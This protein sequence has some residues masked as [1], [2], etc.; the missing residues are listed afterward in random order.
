[1]NERTG[2]TEDA[3]FAYFLHSLTY[4][5]ARGGLIIY[6]KTAMLPADIV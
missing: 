4:V 1:M 2:A 6:Y 3:R 5:K